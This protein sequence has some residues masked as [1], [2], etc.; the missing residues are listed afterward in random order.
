MLPSSVP[1]FILQEVDSVFFN[2]GK[3]LYFGPIF[4]KSCM[5][6][7]MSCAQT[8]SIQKAVNSQEC[9]TKEK[10]TRGILCM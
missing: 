9:A 8:A 5:L 4:V 2:T 7:V 10:H 6:P 3:D 1:V